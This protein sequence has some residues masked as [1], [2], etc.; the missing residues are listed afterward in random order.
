MD[1]QKGRMEHDL[2]KLTQI[3]PKDM[4]KLVKKKET[5]IT[6]SL[7]AIILCVTILNA[8]SVCAGM[9]I[10]SLQISMTI[11]SVCHFRSNAFFE[12]IQQPREQTIEQLTTKIIEFIAQNKL[13]LNLV[14]TLSF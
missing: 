12:R 3:F 4:I 13:P 5:P 9:P 2:Q 14:T 10:R 1:H 8:I 11:I 7:F 6:H